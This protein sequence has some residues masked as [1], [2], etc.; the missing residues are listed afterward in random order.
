MHKTPARQPAA[1]ANRDVH[2]TLKLLTPPSPKPNFVTGG[3]RD[4]T[5]A[6]LARDAEAIT[7]TSQTVPT[8]ASCIVWNHS[9]MPFAVP[10]HDT[11]IAA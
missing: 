10:L 2:L 6:P 4:P 3:R 5:L 11:S 8:T 1:A 9:A 7:Q